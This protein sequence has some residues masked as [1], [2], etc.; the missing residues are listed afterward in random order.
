MIVG[1]WSSSAYGSI[2]FDFKV[3]NIVLYLL[4]SYVK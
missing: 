4:S 2:E 1:L 3:Y